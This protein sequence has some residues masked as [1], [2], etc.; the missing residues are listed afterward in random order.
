M[1]RG[2]KT[3]LGN[4]K[5][6]FLLTEGFAKSGRKCDCLGR[7]LT[8]KKDTARM[9]R[10]MDRRK[11]RG[12]EGGERREAGRAGTQK[13]RHEGENLRAR[14]KTKFGR[15]E[16][17]RNASS[18]NRGLVEPKEKKSRRR[19]R[20]ITPAR[21]RAGEKDVHSTAR[22]SRVEEYPRRGGCTVTKGET[23]GI[24]EEARVYRASATPE[25]DGR[26]RGKK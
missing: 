6:R 16:K 26:K 2:G 20:R 18:G 19:R 5:P 23:F 8:L 9:D 21:L 14:R 22:R 4:S 15:R 1:E 25:R 10:G 12:R 11:N 3:I 7:W 24:K 13:E 17:E